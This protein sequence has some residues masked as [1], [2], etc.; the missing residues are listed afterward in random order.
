VVLAAARVTGEPAAATALASEAGGD[1]L[2]GDV[3][4]EVGRSCREHCAALGLATG[5]AAGGA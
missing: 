2:L 4:E 5:P 3:V 1:A